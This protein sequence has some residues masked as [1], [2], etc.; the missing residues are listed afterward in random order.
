MLNGIQYFL[1]KW[2]FRIIAMLLVSLVSIIASAIIISILFEGIGLSTDSFLFESLIAIASILIA[3]YIIESFRKGSK[4]SLVG[5]NIDR[6]TWIHILQ[7]MAIVAATTAIT[8]VLM[9]AFGADIQINDYLITEYFF[10]NMITFLLLATFEEFLFRGVI[11]QALMQRFNPILVAIVVSIG[12]ALFH[13]SNPNLTSIGYL[14]IFLAGMLMNIMYIQTRSLWLP[15]SF[16]FFWNY[17]LNI[18][19][20]SP[21]SGMDF[22]QPLFET[23]FEELPEWLFG[24]DFGLEGGLLASLLLIFA[25]AYVLKYS[26]FSPYIASKLFK[27]EYQESII[28]NRK[29]K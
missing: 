4:F 15:I 17:T 12:F 21:V 1:A 20:D 2:W 6:W 5:L 11:M 8:L 25:I 16:H 7:G 29:G 13:Y 14:N 19:L 9:L 28:L 26:T 22:G 18:I 3:T 27:R 23:N 24:G 10:E